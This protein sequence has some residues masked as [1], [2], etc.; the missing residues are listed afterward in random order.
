[1]VAIASNEAD[2]LAALR[3]LAIMDTPNEAHFDAVCRLARDLFSVP[4]ALVSL[5]EENRQWFKAKCGTDLDGTERSIAFCNYTILSD[6]V[7]VVEDATRD[8]RF[9]ANPMVQGEQA[10]RF[11]AGAPLMLR[12]GIHVG[13]LCIKDTAA[14]SF[15]PEQVRQL[16]D[17]AEIV[18]AHLHLRE[19]QRDHEAEIAER[20][21][22]ERRL[23]AAAE[24]QAIAEATASLGHWRIDVAGR[25]IAWSA[26]IASVF[27]RNEALDVLDLETHL[28]LY[29]PDDR[30]AVRARIEAAMA[31]RSELPR[32][33]YEHRSRVLRPD[34]EVR[35]VSVHGVA[36]R[37]EAGRVLS[38]HGV[39]LDVTDLA[40]S[41]QELRDTGA[42]LRATLEA[43]GQGLVMTDAD[44]RV[45]V[46]NGRVAALMGV[47]ESLLYDGAP[48][49]AVRAYQAAQGEFTHLPDRLRRWLECGE[50]ELRVR[51]YERE[52]PNGTV[53]EVHT[54]PVAMGGFVRTFTDVTAR[55]VAER[56]LSESEVQY[57]TLAD[58]LPQLV[59]IMTEVA[60]EASYV[61][62]R[63]TD[64]YG[65]I[66][67][68]RAA[69]LA[70]NHPDDAGRMEAAWAA[71][72]YRREG[73]EVEGRLRR[74]DGTYRWHKLVMKPVCSGGAVVEWIGTALDIDDL[75]EARHRLEETTDL[76]RLAQ[77]AA[78]A[79]LWEWDIGGSVRLS[80]AGAR[81][82]G[83]G[84]ADGP[85]E[86]SLD[87][88][89]AHVW[90]EDRSCL[91]ADVKRALTAREAYTS[92]FRVGG[93]DASRS[94]RWL[95]TFGRV[96]YDERSNDP[97]RFVGL[98]LDVTTRR[99]AEE[100]L[101]ASEA[102]LRIS[103]ERLAL[104][105]DSGEDCLFDWDLANGSLWATERWRDKLGLVGNLAQPTTS[106]WIAAIH[107][108][109]RERVAAVTRAHLKGLTPSLECEYRVRRTDGFA[110]WVLARARVA[111]RTPDGQALRL[112]G[113]LIDISQRKEAEAR[114]EHMALHD[115]LTGLPNRNLFQKCLD[116][117]LRRAAH[118]PDQ[119][120][121]LALDLDRFKAVN[122]TYGHMAGD[123]VLCL[124]AE[125]L[126]AIVREP[127]TVAR[128]GGDEFAVILSDIDG[129]EAAAQICERIIVAV[130]EPLL[131][132]GR[133]I[134]IGI[135]IGFALLSDDRATAEEVFKRADMALFEA[136]A[137][138]RDTYRMFEA[139]AHARAATRSSLALDMKEAIRRSDF[140]LVYQ[141][142]IDVTTGAI[143]SFEALMR[144]QH[145]VRGLISPGEFIPVAEDAGL[146][147]PL[148]TWA[149]REACTEALNWPSSVRV[150]VNVSA[151]QF[152][153]GLEE[154]VVT[155]LSATGL[156]ARRLQ[157]E[158]TESLL[159]QN[160]DQ[161]VAV[162]HRLRDLGVRIALDDFGTGYSSLSYLR[163]FP[164]HLLKIDR[165][166]IRDI[167]DPDAAAIVRAVV[168]IGERLS[169]GIVA[170]GVE[171]AE[172]LELVR[173]EGCMQ[174]QGYLF[175]KPLSVAKARA[176][177]EAHR[178]QV[179]A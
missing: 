10:I 170:E 136:K 3:Q 31:D 73:Y 140:F 61:N 176:F 65:A 4:I 114:I 71:A 143:V 9:A 37:D 45:R 102:H 68:S 48:F 22:V 144:W 28:G 86:M 164:F 151:V 47:P 6:D 5:V 112:V 167:A 8:P 41:E 66:G 42:L 77:D 125:R 1:M 17:L 14:R 116:H 83:H 172:Q 69:R 16:R 51:D 130:G 110:F 119:Y 142:I 108:E 64:Y 156:P 107:P 43:M 40:R 75:V 29:H 53:L 179:A 104:A 56:A 20:M 98:Y 2:R 34:G 67:A 33:G 175:S 46:H 88:W 63:F 126:R 76:L 58:A 111:S 79:G 109:D 127:D 78:G 57:R 139:E 153:G 85:V 163:R 141:P 158:V 55:R 154:A 117:T 62:R 87:T 18:V 95:Q 13:A 149:L 168:G 135:S 80:P 121:V 157:L 93:L 70:R 15:S 91:S 54:L 90:P 12:S 106:A 19:A 115:A 96:V 131:L 122:D 21:H 30:A 162:L 147:V 133:V 118:A 113:T 92:E 60:G 105:L 27:G 101:R 35:Y 171:T 177:A 166:F 44:D 36:E 124:V 59:W 128:F 11:Y 165:A 39:C 120:A 169:M 152:R 155:A 72:R 173:R 159:A 123:R 148:G 100:A 97:V 138:G 134:D 150:S 81:L 103:E 7:L 24:F 38:I 74:H 52:R 129:G 50:P 25:T 132:D 32:G 137:A 178:E 174:V 49:A 82:L 146:I 26:G 161:A 160:P 89:K 84:E 23:R 99:E 145:P 94:P